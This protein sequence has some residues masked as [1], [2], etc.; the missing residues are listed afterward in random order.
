[1]KAHDLPYEVG[2]KAFTGYLADGSNGRKVPGIL[3]CHQGAGLTDHTRERARMLAELGYVAFALDMYGEVATSREHAMRLMAGMQDISVLRARAIAGLENLKV[4]S[5]VDVN[6]LAAAGY[7][8]GGG[9]VLELARLRSDLACIVAFHP[10]L[11]D[12]PDQ[13]GRKIVCKVMVCAGNHDPLIPAEA[14]EKFIALM[15]ACGADW[16]LLVYGNAGHSF[17]DRSVDALGMTGFSYH[18]PTDRRSWAAMCSLF[19]ESF[20]L[21]SNES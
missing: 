8:F 19:E 3:V 21:P 15:S 9:L 12:L 16:Q 17:T 14:R 7:C 10:G 2:E 1:M 4:Q 18:E 6:R 5:N 20:G 13:D 11:T